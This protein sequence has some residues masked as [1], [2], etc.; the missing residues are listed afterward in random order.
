MSRSEKF[1][2]LPFKKVRGQT[3]PDEM[4]Q[5]SNEASAERIAAAMAPRFV[6]VAA[7][8]VMVDLESGDMADPRLLCK[9]G[10]VADVTAA[11]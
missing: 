6:G 8:A 9:Y 11:M 1:I 5:A 7:Y 3:A 2:V 4:R 10:E